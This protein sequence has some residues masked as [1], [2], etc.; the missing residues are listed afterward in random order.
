MEFNKKILDIDTGKTP[1][2]DDLELLLNLDNAELWTKQMCME[3]LESKYIND[4]SNRFQDMPIVVK[5]VLLKSII[6]RQDKYRQSS[7]LCKNQ[8]IIL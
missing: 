5:D 3:R 1:I 4:R 7:R 8:Q 6:E 2:F